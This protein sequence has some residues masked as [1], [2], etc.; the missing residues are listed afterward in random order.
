MEQRASAY[1]TAKTRSTPRLASAARA[2]TVAAAFLAILVTP[3][4]TGT[5]CEGGEENFLSCPLDPILTGGIL[6]NSPC[7]S[8]FEGAVVSGAAETCVVDPHPQC[9]T[10]VCLAWSGSSPFCTE[11]CGSDAD[12]PT[13]SSCLGSGVDLEDPNQFAVSFCVKYDAI[14]CASDADCPATSCV[15]QGVGAGR[16]RGLE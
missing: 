11:E 7:T 4:V 2:W 9:P 1:R 14:P 3:M 5:G 6:E 8:D 13:G 16:C 10:D 15:I 12:C